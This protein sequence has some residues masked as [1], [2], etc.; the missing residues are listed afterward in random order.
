MVRLLVV[1]FCCV[2]AM[3]CAPGAAQIAAREANA[4]AQT[5]NA[6]LPVLVDTYAEQGFRAIDGAPDE[7][8]ARAAIAAIKR[9][10]E[11]VWSGWEA[12][13][14]AHRAVIAAVV[15]EDAI[16]IVSEA[17][18]LRDAYCATQAA[19]ESL[20]LPALPLSPV[21]CP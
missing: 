19:M 5:A 12:L 21:V 20:E 1:I 11:P 2:C 7:A 16:G 17:P 18:K 8:S 4:I 13:S 14:V 15:A 3:G 10:W 6:Q 9:R